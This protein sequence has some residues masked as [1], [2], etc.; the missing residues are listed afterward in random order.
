[1]KINLHRA[2]ILML[3]IAILAYSA[4]ATYQWITLEKSNKILLDYTISQTGLP[5]AIIGDMSYEI[6]YL[7]DINASNSL[8]NTK[9]HYYLTNIRTLA[10]S[11]MMLYEYTKNEKYLLM[12]T[13][14]KNLESFLLTSI[15]SQKTKKILSNNI[16]KLSEISKII[17]ELVTIE[18]I[19]LVK[20]E[21]LLEL[22][23]SLEA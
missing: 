14:M 20:A 8:L 11:S 3:I 7:L 19:T 23:S 12:R 16:D 18:D 22:T 21:K 5:I 9:L 1:M 17:K 15:N 6:S 10:Y 13:S 2:I 4:F